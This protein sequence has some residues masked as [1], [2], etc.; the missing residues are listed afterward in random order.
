MS[1]KIKEVVLYKWEE[2][3][4]PIEEREVVYSLKADS[5]WLRESTVTGFLMRMDDSRFFAHFNYL[6][7]DE[8]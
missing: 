3:D 7:E 1:S 8:L 5:G 2:Q 4:L 6:E